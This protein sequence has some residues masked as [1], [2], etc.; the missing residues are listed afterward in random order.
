[1][2][3]VCRCSLLTLDFSRRHASC[4]SSSSRIKLISLLHPSSSHLHLPLSHPHLL[5]PFPPEDT[6]NLPNMSA[7]ASQYKV[8]LDL[9]LFAGCARR[10]NVSFLA[11]DQHSSMSGLQNMGRGQQADNVF[12]S[13]TSTWRPLAVARSTSLSRRCPVSWPPAPSTPRSSH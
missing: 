7:P 2:S 13:P 1:M 12:R 3:A 8:R 5:C 6:R 11:L 10:G 4:A 9:L